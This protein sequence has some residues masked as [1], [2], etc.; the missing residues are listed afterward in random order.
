MHA[1]IRLNATRFGSVLAAGTL[2]LTLWS[3]QTYGQGASVTAAAAT[4]TA[5]QTTLLSEEYRQFL[6]DQFGY[7]LPS[8]PTKGDFVKALAAVLNLEPSGKPNPFQ[9]I[10]ESSPYYKSALALYEKGILTQDRLDGDQP[11]TQSTAVYIAVKAAGLKELAY[12]YPAEKAARSLAKLHADDEISRLTPQ[13]AQELAAAADTELLPAGLHEA[14]QRNEPASASYAEILLGRVLELQGLYKHELGRVS[15]PGILR[16]VRDAWNV[17]NLIQQPDL[18][19]I[20]DQALQADLITGYNVKDDRYTPRFDS[21]RS[22]T[23]GHS[24]IDHALQLIGLLRSENMDAR[25][26][27]E[28][29]TSAFIYLKEWGEPVQTDDYKV[30]KIDNGNYIAYAKE[31]DL[32]FEF[33]TAQQKDRFQEIV[34]KYAKK[35]SEDQSGLIAHSWWQPL[36]Y[37]RTELPDYKV[38]ANNKITKGHYY[39]QT[40]SL[41]DKPEVIAEGI[42]KI[43][44]ATKVESYRFWVD[45]P[46]YNYLIGEYK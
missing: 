23:Y 14:F 4:L 13:A 27:L 16:K 42:R 37:S 44:P 31:Y 10:K 25:V 12:T 36:Y 29:K 39:A 45:E 7:T 21:A 15:D 11:L 18:Q 19:N 6:K 30:V 33:A 34:L 24:E 20:V 28:P 17:Q 26:Q 43:S 41:A 22:L 1:A 9:D 40:F 46:F 2:L 32:S 5:E 3:G 35:N 8:S 38:I